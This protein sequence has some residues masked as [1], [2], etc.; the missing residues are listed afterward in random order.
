MMMVALC[1]LIEI[2]L[3]K[4]LN[5]T[6]HHQWASLFALHMNLELQIITY[7]NGSFDNVNFDNEEIDYISTY[8]MIHKFLD[9]PK[10]MIV[11]MLYIILP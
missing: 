3:Y 7:N 8:S 2:S 10:I 4:Y 6:I 1:D 9:I 5:S 11:K